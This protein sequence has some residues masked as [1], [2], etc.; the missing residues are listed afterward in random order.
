MCLLYVT[1]S[2]GIKLTASFSDITVDEL[3]REIELL[4]R[5]N[6]RLGPNAVRARLLG[7]GLKVGLYISTIGLLCGI[8][9]YL[10]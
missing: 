4:V 7:N 2:Y 1:R 10:C 3:K 6:H 8:H 5:G 9:V